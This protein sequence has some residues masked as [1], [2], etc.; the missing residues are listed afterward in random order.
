MF[1]RTLA[2]DGDREVDEAATRRVKRE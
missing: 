2:G 1:P